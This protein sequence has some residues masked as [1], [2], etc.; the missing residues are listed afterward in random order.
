MEVVTKG[1]EDWNVTEESN[2]T[3]LQGFATRG[4]QARK[5]TAIDTSGNMT[6]TRHSDNSIQF[7]VSKA[8]KRGLCI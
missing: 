8:S 2:L 7:Y 6:A 1:L 4:K 5:L 3:I